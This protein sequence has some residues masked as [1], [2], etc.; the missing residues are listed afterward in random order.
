VEEGVQAKVVDDS[1][2]NSSGA[3]T[4]TPIKDELRSRP[5]ITANKKGATSQVP[6]GLSRKFFGIPVWFY[7]G[8]GLFVG[9][10][11]AIVA[12]AR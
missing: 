3:T 8:V 9:L 7:L 5:F 4:Q 2:S 1:T 6:T 12:I 11:F 10:I